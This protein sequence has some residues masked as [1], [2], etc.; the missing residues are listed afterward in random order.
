MNV[1]LIHE[2]EF[3]IGNLVMWNH[4]PPAPPPQNRESDG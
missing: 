4:L 1:I 3:G 2:L